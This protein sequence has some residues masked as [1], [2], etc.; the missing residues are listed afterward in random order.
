M[1]PLFRILWQVFTL[2]CVNFGWAVFNSPSLKSGLRF[3]LSML[4]V[5]VHRFSWDVTMQALFRE[6][7]VYILAG[8]VLS[9]PILKVLREKAGKSKAASFFAAAEPVGYGLVFLWAVS[10]L[11]LGA[12]NPFIYFNF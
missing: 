9:T 10:F 6:Y 7:G 8:I 11:V 1:E 12:H 3:C 2:L 5:Y 4:G